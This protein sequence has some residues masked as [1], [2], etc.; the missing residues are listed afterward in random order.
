MS[1][2]ID[3]HRAAGATRPQVGSEH[4]VIEEEL[5]AALE[6]FDEARL[7]VRAGSKIL[8]DDDGGAVFLRVQLVSLLEPDLEGTR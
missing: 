6:E 3:E 2:L 7:P 5:A 1:H 4:E 8:G